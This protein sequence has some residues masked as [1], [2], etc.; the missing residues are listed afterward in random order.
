M[1][2]T[3]STVAEL[4][5]IVSV[6]TSP[7]WVPNDG[8]KQL[9]TFGESYY[10]LTENPNYNRIAIIPFVLTENLYR[11]IKL[12]ITDNKLFDYVD[13]RYSSFGKNRLNHN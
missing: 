11:K 9:L 5:G 6:I 3:Y 8:R 1:T 12:S 13:G 2:K 7:N 4:K 10:S